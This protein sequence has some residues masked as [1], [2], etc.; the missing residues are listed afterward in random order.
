MEPQG[1]TVYEQDPNERVDWSL[2]D[3]GDSDDDS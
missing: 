2:V 1:S 3:E